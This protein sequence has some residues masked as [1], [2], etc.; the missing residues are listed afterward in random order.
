MRNIDILPADTYVVINKS[1]M[2]EQDRK[3]LN[4]LYLPIVGPIPIMLYFSL[5][6]DLDSLELISD[7]RTHHHIVSNMHLSMKEI[8]TAREKLEAIGLLKSYFKEGSVNNYVYELYSP[9]SAHEIFNHPIL[10]IVLYNNVGSKEYNRLIDY[11]KSAKVNISLYDD[12]TRK[13]SD[14]FGTVPLTSYDVLNEDVRKVNK[15]SLNIDSSFDFDFLISSIPKNTISSRCFSKEIKDLIINLSFI[16]DLDVTKMSNI[17]KSCINEKGNIEKEALRKSC[18]NYYQ[19]DHNGLLPSLIDNLQP[20]YLRKPIGDN[21][22]KAKLIYAFETISP[23]NVLK[24][25][26]NGAEPTHR[27]LKLIEDL[28]VDYDL[29]PGVVNVLID[30]TLR[31]NN[32]KLTRSFVETIAGQWKRSNIETVEDAMN[33]AEKEHKKYNKAKPVGTKIESKTPLWFDKNISKE[34]ASYEEKSAIDEML[35]EFK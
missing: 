31:I 18:R 8:K 24:N 30:Y 27:D 4:M 2:V 15:L 28:V 3:I 23:Y 10:N 5:W 17:I 13:F 11:F 16:Y 22:K 20:E 7:E 12:I 25:K 35:K 9:L 33:M 21:S 1:I 29:K 32:N 26:M 14:V 6:S 34:E 19:F